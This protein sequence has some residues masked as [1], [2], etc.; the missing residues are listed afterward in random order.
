MTDLNVPKH[1]AGI[2]L[3][4][5]PVQVLGRYSELDDE[6]PRKVLRLNFAALFPPEPEEGA[7]I[8]AHNDPCIGAADK[9]APIR[10]T[11]LCGCLRCRA[12]DARGNWGRNGLSLGHGYL[13]GLG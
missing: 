12:C 4:P 13:R 11:P 9:I 3:V 1:L 2:G 7:F 8:V 10:G 5:A 6:I